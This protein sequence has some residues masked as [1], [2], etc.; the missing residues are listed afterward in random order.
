M[1]EPFSAFTF[2]DRITQLEPGKRAQG[3]F[4]VPERLADFRSSL[5]AEAVGQLAAWVSMAHHDFRL[6]P[7]AGL[8]GRARFLGDVRPGELLEL[9]VELQSCD[10]DAVAYGGVA[11][12]NG[13]RVL[14]LARCLG[15]MLPLADFDAPDAVRGHFKLLCASGAPVGRFPGIADPATEIVERSSGEL[16]ATLRVPQE[17]AFFDDHFP[18]RAVFPGTLLLDAQIRLA[19]ELARATA[20]AS[21]ELVPTSVSN[22]KIRAFILPGQEVELRAE[23]TSDADKPMTVALSARVD[24]KPVSTAR[25]AIAA[26]E[27]A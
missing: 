27:A 20:R 9:E 26:R 13:A 17:A 15:P 21:E 6:R 19:L 22:V 16:R 5:I 8:A 23:L 10:D 14:E 7:V 11:R 4:S 18:R 3:R 2:V 24:D 1:G 25:M 12:V